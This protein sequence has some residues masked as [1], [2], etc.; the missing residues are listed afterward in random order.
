MNNLNKEIR[1]NERDI[2]MMKYKTALSKVGF[3][4]EIKNGL[5]NDI[6]V[7]K[8]YRVIK[9]TWKQKLIRF[10]KKLFKIF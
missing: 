8:G 4:S 5:G 1:D 7:K 6:K 9:L 2:E 3:I 10:L